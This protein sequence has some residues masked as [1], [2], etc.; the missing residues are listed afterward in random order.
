MKQN[1]TIL[2]IGNRPLKFLDLVHGAL[3]YHQPTQLL[4]DQHYYSCLLKLL[5]TKINYRNI[6]FINTAENAYYTV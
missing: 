1:S 3:E 4:S 5:L 2:F 6:I